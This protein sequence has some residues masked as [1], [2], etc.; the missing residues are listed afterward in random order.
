[1]RIRVGPPL[2]NVS[3]NT[4]K[5]TTPD[6]SSDQVVSQGVPM[7]NSLGT[8]S[9]NVELP[10]VISKDLGVYEV[11]GLGEVTVQC[12]SDFTTASQ[13]VISRPRRVRLLGLEV[14]TQSDHLI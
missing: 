4:Q 10:N 3:R 11:E 6:N 7:A 1:M 8:V 13:E 12:S 2:E 5:E 14:H 9:A